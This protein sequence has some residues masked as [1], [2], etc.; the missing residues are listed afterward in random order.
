MK[1]MAQIHDEFDQRLL[2][3]WQRDFPLT[4]RPFARIGQALGMDETEVIARLTHLKTSGAITRVGATVRPNTIAASTLAAIAAP[5]DRIEQIAAIIGAE[6]GVNHSYLRE[7]KWNLWF[8][9]T[10]PDADALQATL[11][12]IKARTGLPLLD[13]RLLRAFNIDLGFSLC[14]P[15]AAMPIHGALTDLVLEDID[16]PIMQ[17]LTKGLPLVPQPF[18]ALADDL[19]QTEAHVIERISTLAE[20]GYLTRIGVIVRHR[21]LGWRSNAMV[22]WQVPV[23][24]IVAAG[25]MLAQQPGITLCYQRKIVPDAWPYSLYSMIHARSRPEAIK[26]LE[27]AQSLPELADVQFEVLFSTHCYKQTGAMIA[28]SK[29]VPDD[30]TKP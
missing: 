12:R 19:G 9:V 18:A 4:P 3:D 11:E 29:G 2:E 8:V 1:N 27:Q 26:V 10:A 30:I 28:H 25:E 6:E 5:D 17:A 20:A 23:D 14:A 22:V 13:L 21:A 7:H 16:R 15:H 24:R